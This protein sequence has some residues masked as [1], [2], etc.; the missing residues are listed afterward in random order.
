V[1][2]AIS[3]NGAG[4]NLEEPSASEAEAG[5]I[6]G[7]GHERHSS[8]VDNSCASFVAS[9]GGLTV[10]KE[11]NARSTPPILSPLP[12]PATLIWVSSTLTQLWQLHF[13]WRTSLI[14]S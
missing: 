3:G 4:G 9:V 8:P 11:V 2:Q 14:Q 10:A 13:S 7:A 12:C 5:S 1:K 6:T